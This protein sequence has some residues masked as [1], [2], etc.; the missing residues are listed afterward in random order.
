MPTPTEM[1]TFNQQVIEEFRA[2]DGKVS[3]VFAGAPLLLLTTTGAKSGLP[4]TSPLVHTMDGDHVVI[5]AS[6]GGAPTDPDWYRNLVA[7]PEVKVELPAK[8]F[9]A[10][11]RVAAGEERDRLFDAQAKLMPNFADYQRNTERTIPV[12]VLERVAG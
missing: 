6:K 9:R 1:L 12:V 2:N 4:R 8:T 5:I 10:R 11:A 3:G 7:D